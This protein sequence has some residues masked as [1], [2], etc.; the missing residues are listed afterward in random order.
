[1]QFSESHDEKTKRFAREFIKRDIGGDA[2]ESIGDSAIAAASDITEGII[3]LLPF[4][5]MPEII[6][7][8]ILPN[9]RNEKDIPILSLVMDEYT[10]KAGF[11]TR[12]EAF[13]DLIKRR[14]NSKQLI[15]VS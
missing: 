2:V 6:A 4:T 7:Q 13:V 1:M 3:H 9:V 5:C 12:L 11:V 10:G 14:K 8:N 15:T